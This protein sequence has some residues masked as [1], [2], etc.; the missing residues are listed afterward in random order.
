MTMSLGVPPSK[1]YSLMD[2]PGN[3]VRQATAAA[4][5]RAR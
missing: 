4:S 2:W 5:G 3:A 1:S